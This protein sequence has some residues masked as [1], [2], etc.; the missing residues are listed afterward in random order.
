MKAKKLA[1]AMGLGIG[2]AIGAG[3]VSAG[4]SVWSFQDD[5]IDF[6]LRPNQTTGGLDL[7]DP[8]T[9]VNTACNIGIGDVLLSVFRFPTFTID[10]INAIPTGQQATGI[11]AIQYYGNTVDPISQNTVRE[12]GAYSGGLDAILALGG[13]T[14]LPG[15]LGNAGD[16]A[17][18]ATF[19]NGGNL[20]LDIAASATTNCTNLA[21]CISQAAGGRSS[22]VQVDGG[23]SS[24]GTTKLDPDNFWFGGN[25]LA[26]ADIASVYNIS[27]F[28]PVVDGKAGLTTM[29][30]TVMPIAP[31]NIFTG[32]ACGTPN[33]S[34]DGC[35]DYSVLFNVNG[36]GLNNT[37][38]HMTNGAFARGSTI[39][40]TKLVLPEPGTLALMGASLLGLLGFRRRES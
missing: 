3:S 4:P 35:V 24:D 29:Y 2:L 12:F 28:T 15:T 8:A 13:A 33:G 38:G 37:D 5:L 7:I 9:C 25:I 27:R 32:A 16:T 31:Q 20:I 10:G 34:A 22:L 40:A 23:I 19:L 26:G 36:G 6:L 39:A 11:A 18:V 17:M 21:D 30:N 1:V 14:A